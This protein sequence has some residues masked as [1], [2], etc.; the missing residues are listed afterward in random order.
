MEIMRVR[1][2]L[3]ATRRIGGLKNISLRVLEDASG[4]LSVACDPIGV[5]EGSWVFTISGSAARYGVGDFDILTDM[6]IG[7]IIDHWEA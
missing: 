3:I 4:K 5:P 7:G 1:S 6:T 2:D